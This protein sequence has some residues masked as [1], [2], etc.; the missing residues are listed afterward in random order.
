MSLLTDM[1]SLW[2]SVLR[3]GSGC[4][5]SGSGSGS[6]YSDSSSWVYHCCGGYSSDNVGSRI[7]SDFEEVSSDGDLTVP[8]SSFFRLLKSSLCCSSSFRDLFTH[9]LACQDRFNNCEDTGKCVRNSTGM[10]L[11]C[12]PLPAFFPPPLAYLLPAASLPELPA[13]SR[14]SVSR[15]F[16]PLL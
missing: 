6:G 1:V 7:D 5:G 4:S 3:L 16:P 10:L 11:F 2:A 13:I 8:W 12:F 15:R 14:R 9:S